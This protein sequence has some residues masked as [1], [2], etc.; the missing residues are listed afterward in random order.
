M[1]DYKAVS[2]NLMHHDI[3]IT[4]S[5]YAPILSEEVRERIAGLSPVS[6]AQSTDELISFVSSL[7]NAELSKIMMTIAD[8]LAS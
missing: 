5:L 4:D 3:E 6:T 7:S 8:R 2:M 1:A